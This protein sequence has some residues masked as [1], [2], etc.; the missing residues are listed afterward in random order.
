MYLETTQQIIKIG[1]S[2]CEIKQTLKLIQI[3]THQLK[4]ELI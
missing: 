1:S 2:S 4:N 3:N